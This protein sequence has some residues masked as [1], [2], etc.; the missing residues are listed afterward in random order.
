MQIMCKYMLQRKKLNYWLFV[1]QYLVQRNGKKSI[2]HYSGDPSAE[3]L[4]NSS[5]QHFL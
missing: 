5:T 1:L 3:F 4:S 2:N